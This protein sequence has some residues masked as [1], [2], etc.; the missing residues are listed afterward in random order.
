MTV[1]DRLSITEIRELRDRLEADRRAFLAEYEQDLEHERGIPVD[2]VGD[3]ADRAEVESD[4]GTLLSAAEDELDRL[5][6][7]DDAL[8]RMSDGSY[9]ICLAGGE[10]IPLERLRAVP[11]TRYCATHQEEWEDSQRAAVGHSRR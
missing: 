5:R 11:W 7:I 2:E 9:G 8:H 6:L 3:L 10:A 4:R 1:E